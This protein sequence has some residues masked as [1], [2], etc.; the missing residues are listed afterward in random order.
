MKKPMDERIARYRHAPEP[1]TID[2]V[3]VVQ[4]ARQLEHRLRSGRPIVLS[5]RTDL[6]LARLE[7]ADPGPPGDR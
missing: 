6:R 5:R 2:D 4:R 1:H 3:A 7:R